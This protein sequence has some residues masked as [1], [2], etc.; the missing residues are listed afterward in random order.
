M[1]R[2]RLARGMSQAELG[3]YLPVT[4]QQ[5]QKYKRAI[6]RVAAADLAVFSIALNCS[7]NDFFEVR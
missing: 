4:S 1:R 6:N 7:I 3:A 5:I 2:L